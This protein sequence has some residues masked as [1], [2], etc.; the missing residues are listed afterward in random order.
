MEGKKGYYPQE[1]QAEMR[2]IKKYRQKEVRRS[3]I[4]DDGGIKVEHA[5]IFLRIIIS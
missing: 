1:Q 3:D 2:V 5:F 4:M